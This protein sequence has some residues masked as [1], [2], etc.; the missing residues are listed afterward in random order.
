MDQ[1]AKFKHA[2]ISNF[3][4]MGIDHRRS[5]I[6]AIHVPGPDSSEDH[7]RRQVLIN[8]YSILYWLSHPD[9]DIARQP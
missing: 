7:A 2:N 3:T 5:V 6:V 8:S 9:V 1:F 4:V